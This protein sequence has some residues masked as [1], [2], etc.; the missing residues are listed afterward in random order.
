MSKHL[1]RG[2]SGH[3]LRNASG[4]LTHDCGPEETCDIFCTEM[5]SSYTVLGVGSLVGC[6]DC[7]NSELP[8]WN[9]V[10]EQVDDLCRWML[11]STSSVAGK[12]PSYGLNLDPYCEDPTIVNG[13]GV[14]F[15]RGLC[16]WD[17]VISCRHVPDYLVI[18]AG[19]KGV[20][21]GPAGVYE[22]LCGCDET[23]TLTVV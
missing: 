7:S 8:P 11:N 12:A 16:R 19:V 18:W 15:N 4:R 5:A 23:P 2:S 20:G 22:R 17:L 9:G 21:M 10:I 14:W 1:T 3:L 13:I 6:G